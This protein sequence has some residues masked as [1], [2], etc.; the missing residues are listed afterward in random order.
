MHPHG[1]SQETV[2]DNFFRPPFPPPP[3]PPHDLW[4]QCGVPRAQRLL[5]RP[6]PIKPSTP[7]IDGQIIVSEEHTD[8]IGDYMLA[9]IDKGKSDNIEVGQ[10][11]ELYKKQK[12]SLANNTIATKGLPPVGIGTF[13]VLHTEQTTSTVIVTNAVKA[14]APGERFK[15]PFD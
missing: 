10:Q 2:P 3:F 7:G 14:I 8:L 4:R 12:T 1:P 9:F 5:R 6:M 13:L 11:Y 15:T